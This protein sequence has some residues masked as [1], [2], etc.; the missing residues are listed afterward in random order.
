MRKC[1]DGFCSI[2]TL[3]LMAAACG[4]AAPAFSQQPGPSAA[5][6]PKVA[7]TNADVQ[8]LAELVRR[9]QG[10]LQGLNAEIGQLRTEQQTTR[11]EMAA[12]RKQL[13]AAGGQSIHGQ[14]NPVDTAAVSEAAPART[15]VSSYDA[16]PTT[17]VSAERA[18]NDVVAS[19][20]QSGGEDRLDTL[21]ENLQLTNQKIVEQ[22]Q[23]KIES[24]SKYRLRLSGLLLLNLFSN[25]GA[26][27]NQELPEFAT[28]HEAGE[29]NST[30]GGSLRQ[31]EISLQTFGPD[32]AGA[33][34]S[35]DLHFDFAGGTP[36]TANGTAMGIVRLRTATARFDWS[37]TSIIAGQD[38]MFFLPAGPTSVVSLASPALSYS[39]NLWAWSPQIR[40]E[41]RVALSDHSNITVQ[42]GILDSVSGEDAEPSFDREPSR[43]EQSGQPAY[44]ARVALS[45]RI[46]GQQLIAGVGGYYGRQNWEGRTIDGWIGSADLTLPIGNRFE[47]SGDFYRG[48]AV[49]GFGGAIG[50]TIFFKNAFNNPDQS[51]SGLD[52]MGGWIQLKYKATTKFQI[53]AAFGDDNPFAAELRLTRANNIPSSPFVP[54]RNLSPFFNFIYQPRSDIVFSGEYRYLKTSGLDSNNPNTANLLNFAIGYIF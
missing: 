23:T 42:A 20:S 1:R 4:G 33:H 40:V 31:S 16:E 38:R 44:A 6:A 48:R 26:V 24:G 22:S 17:A 45:E 29:A 14:T 13:G 50:Q 32:I 28:G 36:S 53:N 7:A 49:G 25:R 47:F 46:F 21:E 52:S 5:D 39:G 43:G 18:A 8:S 12:L 37:N 30:F 10:Q 27:E 11:T 54:S 34:T 35:A 9:L 15:A 19:S 41:H 2:R 51:V 3:I